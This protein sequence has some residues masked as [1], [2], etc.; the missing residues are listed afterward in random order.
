[1]SRRIR[2]EAPKSGLQTAEGDQYVHGV[3]ERV[4]VRELVFMSGHVAPE[5][6]D[7]RVR[8]LDV[9]ASIMVAE[10][11]SFLKAL[12]AGLGI[13]RDHVDPALLNAISELD[14]VVAAVGHA[15]RRI[16]APPS[17]ANG[18]GRYLR[19]NRFGERDFVDI[20]RRKVHS[21]RDGL[22]FD[23]HH[24]LC[25]LTTVCFADARGLF[26][27]GGRPFHES[28][29]LVELLRLVRIRER[30][31]TER[32]PHFRALQFPQ[33]SPARR[34]RWTPGASQ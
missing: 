7:P 16:L 5:V 24:E 30:R 21:E 18:S 13:R 25:P 31:P 26:L 23:Q 9:P 15:A 33:M 12:S 11:A 1:M 6:V 17:R 32:E 2:A 28:F 4:I 14:A 8:A 19:E 3:Q 27:G 10:P 34:V 22:A 29:A 20:G